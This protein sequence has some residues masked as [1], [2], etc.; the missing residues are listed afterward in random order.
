MKRGLF[1]HARIYSVHI[2]APAEAHCPAPHSEAKDAHINVTLPA[3][4]AFRAPKRE[5]VARQ[6]ERIIKYHGCRQVHEYTSGTVRFV[7]FFHCHIA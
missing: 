2:H 1:R 3:G 4:R 7:C 6:R 5:A